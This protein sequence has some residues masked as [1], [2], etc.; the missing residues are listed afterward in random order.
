MLAALQH[1]T[2][3]ENSA[4][5]GSGTL[6]GQ[7]GLLYCLDTGC[8]H[9]LFRDGEGYIRTLDRIRKDAV[10]LKRATTTVLRHSSENRCTHRMRLLQVICLLRTSHLVKVI[11]A[12]W[13][14]TAGFKLPS[15]Q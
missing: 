3:D 15:K 9:L 2:I 1:C 6:T 8:I 11:H 7:S 14:H 5:G 4:P 12:L 13:I 10:F